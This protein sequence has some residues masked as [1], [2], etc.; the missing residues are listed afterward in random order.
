MLVSDCRPAEARLAGDH[1]EIL[2]DGAWQEVPARVVLSRENADGR[3]VACR[4]GNQILCFI[5]P[6]GT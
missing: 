6:A 1:W 2:V 4:A 5:P 3:P